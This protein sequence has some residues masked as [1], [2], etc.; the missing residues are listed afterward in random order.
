MPVITKLQNGGNYEKKDDSGM[1]P[2]RADAD[3]GDPG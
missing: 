3:H 1:D 2:F